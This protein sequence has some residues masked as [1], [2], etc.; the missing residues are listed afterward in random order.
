MTNEVSTFYERQSA[1]VAHLLESK[2]LSLAQDAEQMLQKNLPLAAASYFEHVVTDAMRGFIRLKSNDCKELTCLFDQKIIKRQYHTLF[3]WEK[4]NVNKFLG[5]FGEAFRAAA[6]AE[7]AAKPEL[8][9][10]AKDFLFIGDLRNN[11]IHQNY[12]AYTSGKSAAEI[13]TIFESAERFVA[14]ARAKLG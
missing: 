9:Q 7:I 14:F 13:F 10:A 3:D 5:L 12:V 4:S 6:V 2:E 1:L 11:I 8:A